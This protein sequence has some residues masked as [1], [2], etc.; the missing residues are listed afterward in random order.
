M[1]WGPDHFGCI[2]EQEGVSLGIKARGGS[3]R[4]RNTK[5]DRIAYCK[6]HPDLNIT[7]TKVKYRNIIFFAGK[8]QITHLGLGVK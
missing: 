2:D 7:D 6:V 5:I 3:E 4:N 8:R 1:I